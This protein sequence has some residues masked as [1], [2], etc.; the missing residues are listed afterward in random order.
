M[1]NFHQAMEKFNLCWDQFSQN[2]ITSIKSLK[3]DQDFTDVT[4]ACEENKYFKAHKVILS[5]C[6]DFFK[7]ILI[8][9]PHQHPLIYLNGINFLDLQAILN[10]IYL[11]QTEVEQK[12]LDCFMKAAKTLKIKGLSRTEF[13][14]DQQPALNE[15]K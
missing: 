6:S 3:L 7:S 12:D 1:I 10:F 5:S 4:L 11:G 14:N 2:A 8:Q 9:N 13:P 15:T